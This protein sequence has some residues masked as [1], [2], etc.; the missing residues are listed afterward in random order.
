[1]PTGGMYDAGA[2]TIMNLS[3]LGDIKGP[4]TGGAY[5]VCKLLA[6]IRKKLFS[7]FRI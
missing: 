5:A 7:F 4:V 1:M 3:V 6:C 2:G